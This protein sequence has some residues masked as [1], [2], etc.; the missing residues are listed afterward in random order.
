MCFLYWPHF[1]T[2]KC[3]WPISIKETKQN[4]LYSIGIDPFLQLWE[5]S[6]VSV[7]IFLFEIPLLFLKRTSQIRFVHFVSFYSIAKKRW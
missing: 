2:G 5:L 1:L 6:G 7:A 3:S 4:E